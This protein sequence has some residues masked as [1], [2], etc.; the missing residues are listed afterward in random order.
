VNESTLRIALA[1][2]PEA[3]ASCY[4]VMS[5]LRPHV[6]EADFVVRVQRQQATGYRLAFVAADSRVTAVAGFR[7]TE[8]LVWG[9]HCF[10]DDLVTDETLRSQGH[11]QALFEWLVE[12]AREAGCAEFH[13]DSGVQRFDAHRFY[14]ARRMA[15]TSYHFGLKLT[16]S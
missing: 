16:G 15:I 1:E 7:F 8:N 12:R 14:F 2:T 6:P 5:Q 9:L 10:V 11:G 3:I 4:P 13:L